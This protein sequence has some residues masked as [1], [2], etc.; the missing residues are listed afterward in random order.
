MFISNIDRDYLIL[1]VYLMYERSKGA[2]SFWHAYFD[3]VNPG[4]YTSLW[5]DSVIDL[6]DD[7]ELKLNLKHNS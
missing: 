3:A 5:S 7:P 6:A 4:V 1:V 2:N